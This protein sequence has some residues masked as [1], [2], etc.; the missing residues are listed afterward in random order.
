MPQIL[1]LTW[2]DNWLNTGTFELLQFTFFFSYIPPQ[3]KRN[4]RV[5]GK[6]SSSTCDIISFISKATW[7]MHT[8]RPPPKIHPLPAPLMFGANY[9]LNRYGCII[10]RKESQIWKQLHNS[11][12]GNSSSSACVVF[13]VVSA[14]TSDGGDQLQASS[15]SDWKS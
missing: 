13:Y 5:Y 11:A 12:C 6:C 8:F 4:R 1:G 3:R 9:K 2:A 14:L 15:F 10:I 7:W